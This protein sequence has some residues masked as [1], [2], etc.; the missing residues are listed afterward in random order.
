MSFQRLFVCLCISA[1][2]LGCQNHPEQATQ[3]QTSTTSTAPAPATAATTSSSTENATIHYTPI[4]PK[5]FVPKATI[6]GWINAKPINTA[7]ID[8]H[9]WDLWGAM[10]ADSGQSLNGTP[11]PVWETWYDTSIV[12]K[13]EGVTLPNEAAR[14]AKVANPKSHTQRR[15]TVPVQ[16]LKTRLKT[17]SAVTPGESAGIVLTFNRFT[18]EMKDHVW[19]NNYW[20]AST[21]DALNNAWPTS[22]KL[23][24]RVIKPFHDQSIMMKPVFVTVSGTQPTPLPYWNGTGSNATSNPANPTSDTWKQC[25][26]VDPTGTA[27]NQ[28][29]ITCNK[30]TLPGGSYQVVRISANPS[31]S[32]L[33]AFQLTQQEVADIQSLPSDNF[34]NPAA[35]KALKAGD[36]ALF[37]GGHVSTREIDNWT[38]QTFWWEPNTSSLPQQPPNTQAAPT[39][40]PAP[41]S[42]YVSCTAYYM[43]TPPNDPKGSQFLCYNPYLETGLTGLDNADK[44]VTTGTGVQTNCM[45]CHRA[46][47]WPGNTADYAIDFNLMPGDPKWFTGN[48]KTDFSWA[49]VN[50]AH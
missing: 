24:D 50:N 37:V 25:V 32:G 40:I 3:P 26:L 10:T 42:H 23:A 41:W 31:Q 8:Q 20:Q 22:T 29:P 21:L 17:H 35:I 19:Q 11:L 47:A 43:V 28:N 16:F 1:A 5:V 4:N 9:R 14:L 36:Y 45:T 48:T 18:Q 7:A 13:T 49:M 39:A 27:T 34:E 2:V 38:W 15:F 44:S 6:D 33:Y 46:A 30:T 12:F